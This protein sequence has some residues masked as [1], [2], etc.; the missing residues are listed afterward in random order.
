MV[1]TKSQS[2]D[3]DTLTTF[4]DAVEEEV[5]LCASQGSK[6]KRGCNSTRGLSRHE[7]EVHDDEN[8]ITTETSCSTHNQRQ[9][10]RCTDNNDD[11]EDD[12]ATASPLVIQK[13]SAQWF[14]DDSSK[15]DPPSPPPGHSPSSAFELHKNSPLVLV[16]RGNGG[17]E[18][19][20]QEL[21]V[22]LSLPAIEQERGTQQEDNRAYLHINKESSAEPSSKFINSSHGGDEGNAVGEHEWDYGFITIVRSHSHAFSDVSMISPIPGNS[23]ANGLS[24]EN[25]YA[26][27]PVPHLENAADRLIRRKEFRSSPRWLPSPLSTGTASTMRQ[28]SKQG[29]IQWRGRAIR[30]GNSISKRGSLGKLTP[31]VLFRK[32]ASSTQRRDNEQNQSDKERNARMSTTLATDGSEGKTQRDSSCSSPRDSEASMSDNPFIIVDNEEINATGDAHKG[33]IIRELDDGGIEC[34]LFPSQTELLEEQQQQ[35][36]ATRNSD[37]RTNLGGNDFNLNTRDNL[38]L[39]TKRHYRIT[40]RK[41]FGGLSPLLK[42]PLKGTPAKKGVPSPLDILPTNAVSVHRGGDGGTSS[43]TSDPFLLIGSITMAHAGPIWRMEFSHDG[44]YLA[45]AGENGLLSI[46]E[47]VP[48]M[49]RQPTYR[50]PTNA[51]LEEWEAAQGAPPPTDPHGTGPP[52]G[53]EV[54]ILSSKPIRRYREHIGDIVDLSW[55]RTNFLLSASIDKTVRLWHVSRKSCVLSFQ[56]VDAVTCVDFHPTD[57]RYFVSGSFDRKVRV[58][59]ITTARVTEWT[60]ARDIVTS[61]RF[62]PSEN[63]VVAGLFHGQVIF[64]TSDG[65]KYYT[66]IS[67]K[68]THGRERRGCKVTGLSFLKT[69]NE[70]LNDSAL[71]TILRA[72]AG[73]SP[74]AL[75]PF[76]KDETS[77][78]ASPCSDNFAEARSVN[79]ICSESKRRRFRAMPS[80]ILKQAKRM[81][82]SPRIINKALMSRLKRGDRHALL[83]KEK[84][85]V[86][87]NDSR[88][89]LF[90]LD[91]YCLVKKYKGGTNTRLQIM[92]SSLAQDHILLS[93]FANNLIS[94]QDLANAALSM[95]FICSSLC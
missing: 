91:D 26:P 16:R 63:Y 6:N 82:I 68:N 62:A 88:V 29:R 87:T 77:D 46:Y 73:L 94:N 76:K 54:T 2:S 60:Q 3:S 59:D 22:S 57:D 50:C 23:L 71:A 53:C 45:T 56:H 5:L 25:P 8:R 27:S 58:W 18:Y 93:F 55:S 85:L 41:L 84:I 32:S 67:A 61:V 43:A 92:V 34:Q 65:L 13:R 90:G 49:A 81:G 72:A 69:E 40:P 79:N 44:R 36:L 47:V 80:K 10:G 39:D 42:S 74:T 52:L 78:K 33:D 21:S 86:T 51:A 37:Q 4:Y 95:A 35:Q 19:T 1:E 66:Q 20:R 24:L 12:P 17:I 15:S 38:S 75:S 89:R 48:K 64:Y 9:K 70:A 11:E 28:S 30:H 83:Y 7:E 31:R 14:D